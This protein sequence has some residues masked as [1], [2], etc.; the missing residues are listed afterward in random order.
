MQNFDQFHGF[1]AIADVAYRLGVVDDRLGE[2]ARS[3]GIPRQELAP[4]VRR[5][6]PKVITT[7]RIMLKTPQAIKNDVVFLAC[8]LNPVIFLTPELLA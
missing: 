3:V 6:L 7:L 5:R 1:I 8:Y 4:V 2:V